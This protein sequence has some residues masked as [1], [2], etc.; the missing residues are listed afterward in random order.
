MRTDPKALVE[1]FYS[2]VWNR[3]DEAAARE[4]LHPDFRFRGSLG[5]E[6]VGPDGF[7]AYLRAVHA[8]L[9]GFTCIVDELIVAGA[10]AAARMTFKGVHRAPFFGIAPTGREIVWAGA[11]FFDCDRGR[12]TRLW[13]LGDIDAVKRQLGVPPGRTFEQD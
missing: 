6:R 10:Q 11:A 7:I 12:I 1:R 13:V 3:S 4:I 2:D 8:A 9:G 5:P